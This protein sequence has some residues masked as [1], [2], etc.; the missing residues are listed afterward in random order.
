MENDREAAAQLQKS[1]P[2]SLEYKIIIIIAH[3]YVFKSKHLTFHVYFKN[4]IIY[5]LFKYAENLLLHTFFLTLFSD[6]N[7]PKFRHKF[8]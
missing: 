1:A 2:V 8:I 5:Y 3:L 6:L 4:T 7:Q